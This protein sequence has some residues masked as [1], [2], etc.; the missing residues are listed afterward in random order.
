L[1]DKLSRLVHLRLIRRCPQGEVSSNHDYLPT[2]KSFDLHQIILSLLRLKENA[3]T[4]KPCGKSRLAVGTARTVFDGIT[5]CPDCSE[6]L[7]TEMKGHRT[8]AC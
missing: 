2:E 1:T 5:V 6:V 3:S 4:A 7:A 8:S